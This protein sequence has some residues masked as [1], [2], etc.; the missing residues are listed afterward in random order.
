MK[1]CAMI[2]GKKCSDRIPHGLLD[3]QIPVLY[4]DF[5]VRK[6][7]SG[8]HRGAELISL[9]RILQT[10][11]SFPE[12]KVDGV[13]TH[14]EEANFWDET[15]R[16]QLYRMI[17]Q[18][19]EELI[20]K[21]VYGNEMRFQRNIVMMDLADIVLLLGRDREIEFWAAKLMKPLWI[22]DTEKNCM[23]PDIRLYR[24]SENG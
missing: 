2:A 9:D 4:H 16:E 18:C 6:I 7:L 3:R 20:L 21:P 13:F 19:D 17:S 23:I 24:S 12:L 22:L 14:E 11:G 5:G 8:V 1:V 10:R 15:E